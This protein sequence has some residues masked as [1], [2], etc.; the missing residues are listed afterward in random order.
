MSGCF[1][2]T[3][4]DLPVGLGHRNGS[5]LHRLGELAL[6]GDMKETV[7]DLGALHL[8]MV[9]KPEATFEAPAAIP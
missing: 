1:L 2:A 3:L 6:E 7:F 9:G 5:R 8:D 4:D